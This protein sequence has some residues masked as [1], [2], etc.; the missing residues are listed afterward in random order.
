VRPNT[1]TMMSS[2]GVEGPV[3]RRECGKG[4]KSSSADASY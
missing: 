3:T 4:R 1:C 2:R